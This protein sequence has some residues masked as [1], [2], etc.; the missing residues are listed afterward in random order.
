MFII[1]ISIMIRAIMISIVISTM[2]MIIIIIIS[3]TLK[4]KLQLLCLGKLAQVAPLARNDYYHGN[5]DHNIT[6]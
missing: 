1:M 3:S 5:D 6:S 2:M 4:L